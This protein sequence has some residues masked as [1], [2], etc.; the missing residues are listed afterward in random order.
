MMRSSGELAVN[1]ARISSEMTSPAV[2]FSRRARSLAAVSTSSAIS[3][4]VLMH[5]MLA[6][7]T[8]PVKVSGDNGKRYSALRADVCCLASCGG[9]ARQMKEGAWSEGMGVSVAQMRGAYHGRR[10]RQE[11]PFMK[12]LF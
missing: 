4:V 2:L 10:S 12:S 3:S 1:A 8:S 7:Q 11:H 6:H 9:D 5:Q